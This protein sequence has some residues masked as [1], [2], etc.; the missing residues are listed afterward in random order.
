MFPLLVVLLDNNFHCWWHVGSPPMD[1]AARPES[2][3]DGF[4]VY[5]GYF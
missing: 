1:A 5:F 3:R 4:H 2:L